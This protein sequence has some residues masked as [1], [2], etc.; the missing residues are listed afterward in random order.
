[1]A[2]VWPAQQD[3]AV[4]VTRYEVTDGVAVL[5]LDRPER[6]NAIGD[7]MLPELR[8]H[9][10]AAE[11]DPAVRALVLTGAGR[12][13]CAG[14]DLQS[15]GSRPAWGAAGGVD[16]AA[17]RRSLQMAELLH[18]MGTVTIAAV[19]GP[20]AGAGMALA[21]ACDIRV[22]GTS[23]VFVTAFLAAGQTGDYGL[24]WTLPRIVGMGWARDLFLR[25][26]RVG[27]DEALRMGL[28]TEVVADDDLL[29]TALAIGRQIAGTA[30]LTAAALKANLN[31]AERASF[32][33][34][35]DAEVARFV[36]NAAT[37]DS[38]EAA[39]A[40]VEKRPPVYRGR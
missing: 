25:N 2:P 18:E 5:T 12:G 39:R 3:L 26:R 38:R 35:L 21:C 36:A 40:F 16:A 30:P 28:V 7:T 6:L 22:A 27:A 14:G 10:E 20:A 19:N 17:M 4:P 24:T 31:D 29:P 32:A 1:M 34:G 33:E 37:E 23:A 11:A 8:A 13:F 15:M 9:L